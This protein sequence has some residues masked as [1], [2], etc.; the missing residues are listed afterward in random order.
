MENI[1]TLAVPE[2]KTAL[3]GLGKV[4]SK[5]TLPV[6]K[7]IRVMRDPAGA[8]S[9]QGTDLD[10]FLTYSS[11]TLQPGPA[12]EFLAPLE[13]LAK[14]AKGSSNKDTI[15]LVQDQDTVKLRTFIGS[16]P[17]DQKLDTVAPTEWPPVPVVKGNSM[18]VNGEFH[19]TLRQAFEC[20]SEDASR[21]ILQGACLDTRDPK[22]HYIASSNGR[23]VYSA[24]SFNFPL[25]ESVVIPNCKFL[26]WAALGDED[27]DLSVQPPEKVVKNKVETNLPGWIQYQT[28]QWTFIT[29]SVDGQFPNWRQ[30][31]PANSKTFVLL[32]DD[33]VKMM[34][35]VLPR[36]PGDDTLTHTI[37][38]VVKN[39]NFMLE[40]QAKNSSE[41]TQVP[42]S[43]S[44]AG[45]PDQRVALNRYN[46]ALALRFGMNEIHLIDDATPVVCN[47]TTKRLII[48]TVRLEPQPASAPAPQ[49]EEPTPSAA[50]AA[51]TT[52]TPP[53]ATPV[54]TTTESAMPKNTETPVT[55]TKPE[56]PVRTALGHVDHVKAALGDVVR[57]LATVTGLL[58]QVEKDKKTS[59][60]EI[61]AVR[62]KLREIHS[63]KI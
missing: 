43:N 54:A 50:P 45:G 62:A 33:A 35:E 41:I 36:L 5:S 63:V 16:S 24:N 12:C 20:A 60:K 19:N 55:E 49:P 9:L 56:S 38:L 23:V 32:K 15:A 47:S 39:G 37:V 59:D 10:S 27:A 58:R 2:L 1:I 14:A 3:T 46:L 31:I 6:L 11:R 13:V 48:A 40:A 8:V 61:E 30:V 18:K 22:A 29:K 28:A 51:D 17:V 21:A 44:E 34:L 42:I 25:K 53:Q 26:N 57:E 7:T 52:P 4:V